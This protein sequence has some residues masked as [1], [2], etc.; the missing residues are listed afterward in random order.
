M[1]RLGIQ[2][3]QEPANISHDDIPP[4]PG[5]ET[6]PPPFL[7]SAFFHRSPIALYD[8]TAPLPA[9]ANQSPWT[10]FSK[11]DCDELEARYQ[12]FNDK[13]VNEKKVDPTN[14][15]KT[16]NGSDENM[17][18]LSGAD[19]EM[20]LVGSERLHHVLFNT[21]TM[22]PVYWSSQNASATQT[23]VR[24]GTWFLMSDSL[25]VSDTL[26]AALERGYHEVKPW[27]QAY[28][29]EL[30]SAMEIGE[31]AETKLKY[32]V[33][34]DIHG[35]YIIYRDKKSAWI[36]SRTIGSRLVKSLYGSIG[37]SRKDSFIEVYRG[38]DFGKAHPKRRTR[39]RSPNPSS[40]TNTSPESPQSPEK[41]KD[42]QG[43]LAT[44]EE[45]DGIPRP[46]EVTD[47]ILVIHGIGQKL[48]ETSEG[49][50][51]THAVNK[52]RLLIHEQLLHKDVMPALRSGFC[53]Q[54][55]PINWR[56]NFDPDAPPVATSQIDE[57]EMFTLDD[58]TIDSI[59]AVR[60][61]IGKVVFDIPYYMS[62]H[63]SAMIAAVVKE[64][65]RI[66]RLWL[67]N[68]KGFEKRGGQA[69]IIC[70]SLGSAISFDVLSNQPTD[71]KVGPSLY[72]TISRKLTGN[73]A[74]QK[75]REDSTFFSFNTNKLICVGSPAAF[76]LLLK[77]HHLLPRRG[78]KRWE[79]SSKDDKVTCKQGTYGCL[80]AKDVYNVFYATDPIAYRM[81]ATIDSS[82][83]S[84]LPPTQL[85]TAS[86]PFFA[87]LKLPFT[88]TSQSISQSGA[89]TPDPSDRPELKNLPSQVELQDH[90]FSRES[91]AD[92]RLH[93][94]NENHQLD[95]SLPS[96]SYM[97]HQYLSMIYA[98][99][100]YWESKEFARLVVLE[101]GKEH[102]EI[103]PSMRGLKKSTVLIENMK[104]LGPK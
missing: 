14:P 74:A 78:M 72:D 70:H 2:Q 63:K 60:D 54:V 89:V 102:G 95:Y 45:Q 75:E 96:T 83:S 65:N 59:P 28:E 1:R 50:T 93:L 42:M 20:L 76:F 22:K 31:S 15:D 5:L 87:S 56:V 61:L 34:G 51:F 73:E 24:R 21:W 101:C 94:L 62:H 44:D 80:A 39:D 100:G 3:L 49:W 33:E 97:E 32:N 103:I 10:P 7:V 29:A 38:Y 98:H 52:L 57:T 67:R 35:Q 48:A 71:V 27:T 77:Q 12:V 40:R 17:E 25:P 84:V 43:D 69:H 26:A 104:K 64:A 92:A 30:M 68:N 90:D 23:P 85:P 46:I 88:S 91:L 9:S 99:Q 53:P 8:L 66:Y 4:T 55:L 11:Y 86:T 82:L 6:T 41:L 37:K 16:P 81:N 13:K 58:I 79:S 36:G 18:G 47:L 19:E